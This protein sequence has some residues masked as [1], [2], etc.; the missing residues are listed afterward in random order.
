MKKPSKLL[1]LKKIISSLKIKQ[2]KINHIKNN[3][4]NFKE[5][6]KKLQMPKKKGK[7]K[8]KKNNNNN[9]K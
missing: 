9:N 4:L 2:Q 1:T 5:I 7:K 6:G 8:K 3:V